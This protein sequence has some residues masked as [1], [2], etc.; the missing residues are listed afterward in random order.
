MAVCPRR[1]AGHLPQRLHPRLRLETNLRLDAGT[2][3]HTRIDTCIRRRRCG[4]VGNAS[5]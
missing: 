2:C 4:P 5:R 3:I 1:L